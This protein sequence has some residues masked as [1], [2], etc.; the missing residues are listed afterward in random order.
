MSEVKKTRRPANKK[1][2]GS[3]NTAHR[4]TTKSAVKETVDF[5]DLEKDTEEDNKLVVV[6]ALAVLVI[7]ATVIGLLVGCQK[8]EEED[9]NETTNTT[10]GDI[11]IPGQD[12]TDSDEEEAVKTTSKSETMYE[13]IYILDNTKHTSKIKKGQFIEKYV[14]SGY[15]SCMY[16]YNEAMTQGVDFSVAPTG[17][18]KVYMSCELKEYTVTYKDASGSVVNTETVK[19]TDT[20]NYKI[21]DGSGLGTDTNKFLGWSKTGD[22]N[23]HYSSG[24]SVSLKSDLTLSAVLGA[25]IV[26]FVNDV[27]ASNDDSEPVKENVEDEDGNIIETNQVTVGYTNEELEQFS[28]PKTPEDAGLT[29]PTYFVYTNEASATSYVVVAD[30]KEELGEREVRIGDVQENKPYW[31]TPELN[32]NVENKDYVFEDWGIPED[33]PGSGYI[34]NILDETYKP[35]EEET[36]IHAIWGYQEEDWEPPEGYD[37][38]TGYEEFDGEDEPNGVAAPDEP[39]DSGAYG[40]ADPESTEPEPTTPIVPVDENSTIVQG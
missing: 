4:T 28:L 12:E 26:K 33:V 29:T 6:I 25:A 5:K 13:I 16:Y 3:K 9:V 10:S 22:K 17:D 32:D 21:M 20:E 7:V 23:I 27:P 35:T 14:P 39:D 38:P 2:T 24:Q 34:Y 30:D 40:S 31:Y 15:K 36:E 11:I 37:R 18:T 19:G 1:P 8:Q